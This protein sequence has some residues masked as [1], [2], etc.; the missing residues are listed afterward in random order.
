MK[1][2][3]GRGAPAIQV[4]LP[5]ELRQ[6]LKHRAVDNRRSTNSEVILILETVKKQQE[7][8]AQAVGLT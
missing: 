1:E 8:K 2:V 3:I 6:W 7:G 5:D 4:R